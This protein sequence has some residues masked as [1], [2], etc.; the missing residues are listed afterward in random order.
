MKCLRDE[1]KDPSSHRM[2]R[3]CK[4]ILSLLNETRTNGAIFQKS[5]FYREELELLNCNQCLDIKNSG[6]HYR[7]KCVISHVSKYKKRSL[8]AIFLL[9]RVLV[10]KILFKP[11]GFIEK[12]N[13]NN[14]V[15]RVFEDLA[16]YVEILLKEELKRNLD[17]EDEMSKGCVKDSPVEK[18]KLLHYG[19]NFCFNFFLGIDVEELNKKINEDDEFIFGISGYFDWIYNDQVKLKKLK[20][21]LTELVKIVSKKMKNLKKE[22]V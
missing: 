3:Y 7:H 18:P 11:Q 9:Y 15:R 6:K 14:G 12:D 17:S 19:K 1:F 21:G 5:H 16:A 22:E 4:S 13:L 2:E 8:I 10:Q 20:V